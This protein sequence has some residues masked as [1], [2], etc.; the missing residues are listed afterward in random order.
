MCHNFGCYI[1]VFEEDHDIFKALLE[2]LQDPPKPSFIIAPPLHKRA[3]IEF[4][5]EEEEELPP[6]Q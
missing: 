2:P 3:F 1:V 6:K 5:K 4:E